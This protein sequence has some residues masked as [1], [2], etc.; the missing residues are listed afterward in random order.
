[1][2]NPSFFLADQQNVYINSQ[3]CLNPDSTGD[4]IKLAFN[5]VNIKCAEDQFFK[6][7][8]KQFNCYKTW[9]NVNANNSLFNIRVNGNNPPLLGSLTHK[10]YLTINDLVSEFASQ[11]NNLL[12]ND[13]NYSVGTIVVNNPI[14]ADLDDN[15]TNIFD[16]TITADFAHNLTDGSIEL[17]ANVSL[18]DFYELLGVKRSKVD[19]D[20]N[21]WIM[22]APTPT[23]LRFVGYYNC[24]LHTEAY[25]YLNCS[26][27]NCC[28]STRNYTARSTDTPGS[29]LNYS[30]ILA[31]IPIQKNVLA[32]DSQTDEF[33]SLLKNI[34]N[35]S[36]MELSLTDSKGRPIPL[37]AKDQNTLGNRS[38]ECLIEVQTIQRLGNHKHHFESPEKDK[39]Y[40]HN[41]TKPLVFHKQGKF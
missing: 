12:I 35:I 40:T 15:T 37:I 30:M 29:Q 16:F 27:T 5:D 25:V 34:R 33:F 20:L 4:D 23:T 2:N 32:Y 13:G 31:K 7:I 11:V 3:T 26:I 21:G 39:V 18:G 17:L 14:G 9:T 24:Q 19:N 22:T 10:N 8:L 28:I 1:M 41:H 36:Y 38:F 6:L